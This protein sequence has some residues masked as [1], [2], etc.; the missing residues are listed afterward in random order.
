MVLN[1]VCFLAVSQ[2]N[3]ILLSSFVAAV[4]DRISAFL[5]PAPSSDTKR[6]SVV[7][8]RFSLSAMQWCNKKNAMVKIIGI[9]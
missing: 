7:G 3:D 5:F 9:R 2:P 8:E 4:A 1:I 6:I